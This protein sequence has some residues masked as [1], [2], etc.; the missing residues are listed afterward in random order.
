MIEP[1]YFLPEYI[2]S[3]CPMVSHSETFRKNYAPVYSI[4]LSKSLD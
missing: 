3:G 2:Q 1:D 4:I